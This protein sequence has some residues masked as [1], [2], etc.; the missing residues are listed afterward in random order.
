MH[1]HLYVYEGI[2]TESNKWKLRQWTTVPTH[3]TDIYFK[4]QRTTSIASK[5]VGKYKFSCAV[6]G[7]F[8]SSNCLERTLIISKRLE[9]HMHLTKEFHFL[10]YTL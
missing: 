8:N 6:W 1:T 9:L 7:D 3:E 10:V 2:Y 4:S 5:D